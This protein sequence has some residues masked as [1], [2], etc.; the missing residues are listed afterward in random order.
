MLQLNINE[1]KTHLSGILSQV[2]K[3]ETVIICRRN[4]PVAEIK[5]IRK[6]P[7]KKRPIGLAGREYPDFKL[8]DEFFEPLPEDILEYFTG[9]KD[10]A[11]T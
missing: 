2:E 4:K 5:P 10:E 6:P 1:V 8:G 9:A 3:G 11:S 7:A